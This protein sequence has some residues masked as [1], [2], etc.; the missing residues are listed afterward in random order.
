MTPARKDELE[1]A[2]KSTYWYFWIFIV[3]TLVSLGNFFYWIN[4]QTALIVLIN[5]LCCYDYYT[6][7]KK[8]RAVY[9]QKYT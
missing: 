6:K 1:N 9:V 7:H 3:C 8:Y 2:I 5:I 4:L